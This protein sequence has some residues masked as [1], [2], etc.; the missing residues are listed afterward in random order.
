M[1]SER[2][3]L[4]ALFVLLAVLAVVGYRALTSGV[5]TPPESGTS[6]TAATQTNAPATVEPPDVRLDALQAQRVSP[7]DN[8]RNLFQFGSGAAAS[9]NLPTAPARMPQQEQ[10]PGQVQPTT[11]LPPPITLKFI[12][13]VEAPN[14]ALRLAI[15]SDGRG[16][17]HGREGDIIEGRYRILTI[18][19]ESVEITH[20][21]GRG[22]QT[23]RLSGS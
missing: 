13:V 14:R 4:V 19:T 21:D 23:I 22:T 9:A 7:G 16:V 5:Q 20:L 6:R 8:T 10:P 18:G 15:L 2:G 1:A 12:G 17:Y 3:K 11:S